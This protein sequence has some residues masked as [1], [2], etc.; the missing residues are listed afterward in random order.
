MIRFSRR[1]RA[2]GDEVESRTQS[3]T[4]F[5]ISRE[6]FYRRL[7]AV[8]FPSIDVPF[9]YILLFPVRT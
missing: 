9:S 8:A 1:K 3:A 7:D 5:L 4:F 2:L 6:Q